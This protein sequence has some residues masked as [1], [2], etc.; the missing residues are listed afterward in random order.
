MSS[1]YPSWGK[2]SVNVNKLVVKT[3][4][5]AKIGRPL[6]LGEDLDK[7]VQNYLFSL[8]Y[9]GGVINITIV[10][11]VATD[12]VKRKDPRLLASNGGHISLSKD[13]ACYML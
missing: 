6:L 11:A 2:E 12:M 8:R 1:I 3:L 4:S 10:Q 9:V 7:K 13:W 5:V